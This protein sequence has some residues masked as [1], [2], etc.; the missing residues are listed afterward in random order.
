MTSEN[1]EYSFEATGGFKI[2]IAQGTWDDF[3]GA[4]Y[5]LAGAWDKGTTTA[6]S[7]LR[8][9]DGNITTPMSN[10]K[11][12]YTVKDDMS[13]ITATIQPHGCKIIKLSK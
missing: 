13:A 12:K 1:G 2:S 9:G 5:Q 8:Q 11:I 6:T 3:N 4:A 10:V 7:T